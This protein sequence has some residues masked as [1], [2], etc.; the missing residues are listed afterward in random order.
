[1]IVPNIT[2][3]HTLE[4]PTGRWTLVGTVPVSLVY[5][6]A[7]GSP[8]TEKQAEIIVLCGPGLLRGKV[9]SITYATREEATAAAA[10]YG[11]T[12]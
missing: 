2:G 6:Q 12:R 11:G 4:C 9:R 5:E 7:D 1:M 8:L 10:P 3:I